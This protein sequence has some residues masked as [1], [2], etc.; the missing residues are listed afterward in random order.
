M[1]SCC[2]YNVANLAGGIRRHGAGRRQQCPGVQSARI[3]RA[4]AFERQAF[5]HGFAGM[6]I[7]LSTAVRTA[8]AGKVK[9]L[10]VAGSRRS[11]LVPRGISA[12]TKAAL[13]AA[14][15]RAFDTDEMKA[16][17]FSRGGD[18]MGSVQPGIR[19]DDPDGKRDLAKADHKNEDECPMSRT[20]RIGLL[21]CRGPSP[22]IGS[23]RSGKAVDGRGAWLDMLLS[24]A[25]P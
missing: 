1:A 4:G 10:A 11:A 8:N 6:F 2:P 24:N 15:T 18:P 20:G 5:G 25:T 14:I 12:E 23:A 13:A 21:P 17:L 7:G 22:I 19:A 3:H 16:K 9:L